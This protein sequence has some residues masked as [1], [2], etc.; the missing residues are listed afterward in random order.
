MKAKAAARDALRAMTFRAVADRY[1]AAHEAT[2]RN[3]KHKYQW[4]VRWK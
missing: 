3:D 4:R 2:W 1:I